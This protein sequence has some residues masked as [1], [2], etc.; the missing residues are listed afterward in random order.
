MRVTTTTPP[1]A[2]RP[3]AA[4]AA[5]V[6]P[7][8]AP[9]VAAPAAAL[10]AVPPGITVDVD[11]RVNADGA[12]GGTG[13][14]TLDRTFMERLVR[15]VTRKEAFGHRDVRYDAAAKAY[16]GSVEVKVKGIKLQIIGEAV[17]VADGGLPAF[18]FQQLGVKVGPFTLR[19]NWV[20]QLAAKLIAKEITKGGIEATPAPGGVIRLDPT[21]LLRDADVLPASL[22]FDT[23][24][25]KFG[26]KMASNGD[27]R[28]DLKSDVPAKPGATRVPGKSRLDVA[29]D[30]TALRH[31]LAPVLGQDYRLSSVK[32]GPDAITLG[33][34]VEAKPLSNA[35][36][37]FKGLIAAVAAANGHAVGNG[38]PEQVMMNLELAAKLQGTVVTLTPS[39]ALA[40]PQLQETLEKAGLAP[41]RV[42]KALRFDIASLLA[43][44]GVTG[45]K[46]SEGKLT[47][48]SD[49][50]INALIKAPIL[51]GEKW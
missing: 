13:S 10:A 42:G 9:R 32:L 12:L 27:V 44:Y 30:E 35:V 1:R 39:L 48:R 14:V 33:G 38:S 17:P 26:V 40:L 34:Q 29:V 24:G 18:K 46:A 20:K 36:N 49:L 37:I 5:P 3:A 28:I 8:A 51:R 6:R 47:G 41:T 11:A 7:D 15:H 2:T 43:P 50:D 21:T 19:G 23:A 45:L 4:P 22:R 25:T 31:A 16:K